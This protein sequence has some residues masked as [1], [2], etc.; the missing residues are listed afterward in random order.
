MVEVF[1]RADELINSYTGAVTAALSFR[2]SIR[3]QEFDPERFTP[4]SLRELC[5]DGAGIQIGPFGAQLHQSDYVEKGVP[6]IMPANLVDEKIDVSEIACVSEKKAQE[7]DV[8]R[9]RP[10]DI[11]LPR[12]GELDKRAY[13]GEENDG[14]L[15]GTGSIRVRVG[16]GVSSRSIFQ[17]LASTHSVRWIKGNAVGT[18]MPNINS[19]IAGNIPIAF[20]PE[21]RQTLIVEQ[22]DA[23]EKQIKQLRGRLGASR[24]IKVAALQQWLGGA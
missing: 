14:W 23:L 16:N 2:A 15:C 18:T 20:P 5:D 3:K 9:I 21:S 24:K 22:L 7:L 1:L 19:D 11:L 6:V 4:R 8:H 13:A 17:A 10:G 12:R